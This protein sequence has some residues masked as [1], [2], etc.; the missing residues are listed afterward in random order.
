MEMK[1]SQAVRAR[2]LLLLGTVVRRR[3]G[4]VDAEAPPTCVASAS[5]ST[6]N[7]CHRAIEPVVSHY[8]AILLGEKNSSEA[9]TALGLMMAMAGRR[10]HS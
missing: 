7:A 3:K 8:L 9:V 1:T 10:Y 4:Q 6:R 5:D 2:R